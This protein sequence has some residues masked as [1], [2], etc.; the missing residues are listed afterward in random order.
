MMLPLGQVVP[1]QSGVSVIVVGEVDIIDDNRRLKRLVG[2]LPTP[3]FFKGH[4]VPYILFSINEV[5]NHE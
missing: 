4:L 2:R 3:H 1:L 5:V